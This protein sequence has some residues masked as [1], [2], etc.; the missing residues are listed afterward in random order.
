MR[1]LDRASSMACSARRMQTA[2]R[3][4]GRSTSSLALPRR[5]VDQGIVRQCL[6]PVGEADQPGSVTAA[7]RRRRHRSPTSAGD[8]HQPE[9]RPGGATRLGR[10]VALASASETT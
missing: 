3:S 7:G 1:D 10:V 5:T 6:H 2:A 4:I 9:V 8:R